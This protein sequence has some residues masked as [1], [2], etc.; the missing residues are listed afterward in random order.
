[1]RFLL[2]EGKLNLC[3]RQMVDYCEAKCMDEP[4]DA[5]LEYRSPSHEPG[6][7]KALAASPSD[8]PYFLACSLAKTAQDLKLGD[9]SVLHG[10]LLSYEESLGQL[11]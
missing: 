1:M 6:V 4:S 10:R 2:E 5:W 3:L 11:L 9:V 7:D 8:A